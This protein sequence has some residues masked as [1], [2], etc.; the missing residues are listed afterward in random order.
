MF[1][2][3]ILPSLLVGKSSWVCKKSIKLGVWLASISQDTQ[4]DDKTMR[5]VPPTISKIA[6]VV[7]FNLCVCGCSGLVG[8]HYR[9]QK[10]HQL[11]YQAEDGIR[12]QAEF[13]NVL[14]LMMY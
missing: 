10:R 1:L 5:P 7:S 9:R 4:S 6:S 3:Y 12:Q 13:F 2:G 14:R 8:L 11:A